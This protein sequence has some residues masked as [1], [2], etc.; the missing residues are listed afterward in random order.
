VDLG[1]SLSQI[2]T[3]GDGDEH[4]GEALRTVDAELAV[5][6]ERLQRVRLELGLILRQSTPTDLPSELAPAADAGLTDADRSVVVVASRVLGPQGMQAYAD[7]LQDLPD[8]RAA[9]QQKQL[10]DLKQQH[11]DLIRQRDALQGPQA[12]TEEAR[13]T[14]MVKPGEKPYVV[15]LPS[16][17]TP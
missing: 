14:G 9:V 10:Q 16:D 17:R 8:D 6:I 11:V 15:K 3:L 4:P 1:F 13:R 5:T 12:I 7:M 2:A